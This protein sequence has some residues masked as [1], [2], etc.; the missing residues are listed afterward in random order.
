MCVAFNADLGQMDDC[1]IA[2][3]LVHHI[4]PLPRHLQ[5]DAPSILPW[6]RTRLFRY[7]I[8]V[9]DH[10]WNF[11]EQHEF[12]QWDSHRRQ[13]STRT[14]NRSRHFAFRKDEATARLVRDNCA[15][16]LILDR[17]PPTEATAV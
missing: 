1:D 17:C 7:E 10:D 14:W 6:I 2:S 13:W 12:T 16:I 3:M 9:V 11:G 4:A 8:T 5:T 15:D